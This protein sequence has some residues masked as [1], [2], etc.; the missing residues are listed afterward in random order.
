MHWFCSRKNVHH[1]NLAWCVTAKPLSGVKPPGLPET[2]T[3]RHL[4][5]PFSR[6]VP[7]R[8]SGRPMVLGPQKNNSK[9]QG[10][11]VSGLRVR[12]EQRLEDSRV[13]FLAVYG[14]A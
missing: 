2:S 3:R 9:V 5:P 12:F 7:R 1:D 8:N 11:Q 13:I 6:N 4:A 14:A 10:L